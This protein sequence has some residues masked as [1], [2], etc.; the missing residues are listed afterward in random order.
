M[1]HVLDLTV[2]PMDPYLQGEFVGYRWPRAVADPNPNGLFLQPG[3]YQVFFYA[4]PAD[5]RMELSYPSETM[6]YR[7]SGGSPPAPFALLTPP[8]AT[9]VDFSP[10]T[11]PSSG[12]FT[13]EASHAIS[14]VG[15]VRYVFRLWASAART[16]LVYESTPQAP[17][18]LFLPPETYEDGRRYW[19]DVVAVDTAGNA[20]A[21]AC[22]SFTASL[23][24]SANFAF[25][26]GRVY[27]ASTGVG[28]AGSL[29]AVQETGLG[30]SL[31]GGDYGVALFAG[32]CHVKASAVGYAEGPWQGLD[33]KPGSID[34]VD[35]PLVRIAPTAF[36]SS[37]AP[38]PT[39]TRLI[40]VTVVFGAAVTGFTPDDI[41]VTNGMVVA[42]SFS[43]S[44]ASYSLDVWPTTDG[45]VTV[46]IA[47][48]VCQDGGG[49]V[50]AT[51]TPLVRVYDSVPPNAPPVSAT[52]PPTDTTP[53]WTWASAGGG[54]TGIFRVQLDGTAGAWTETSLPAF[55][56]AAPL[57]DGLHT[58]FIQERDAAGNWSASGATVV[59]IDTTAPTV[60]L[61]SPAVD[62]TSADPIAVTATCSEA[63]SGFTLS[64]IV[65][66][67]GTVGSFA[68]GGASYNFLVT[69]LTTSGPVTVAIAAGVC[70]DAAGNSNAAAAPLTRFCD[71]VAPGVTLSSTEADPTNSSPF[72]VSV[73]FSEAVGDVALD[74]V[75]VTNGTADDITGSGASY[76]FLVTP[77]EQG[78]VT[79]SIAGGRCQDSAGNLNTASA[80]LRRDYDPVAPAAP[81]V[82]GTTPTNDATPTWS[83]ASGGGGGAGVF[84]YQLDSTAGDWSETTALSFSPAA[85]LADGVHRLYVQERDA[86]GN[87][88]ASGPFAVTVD[89]QALSVTVEQAAGQADPTN[90]S[91]VH[92]TVVFSEAVNGFESDDVSITGTA[93]GPRTAMVSGSGATYSVTVS[94]M[95]G[96]GTVVAALGA[97]VCQDADGNP[98]LASTSADNTVTRDTAPP[99][100]PEISA[101]T[102]TNDAT[103]TWSWASSGG[104]GAGV[105]RYQLDSTAGDWSETTA[106]SFSPAATLA[107]GVH[108]LYVQERDAAGNWSASDPF[109]V[110]VDVQ[111]LSVTVEQAA[112]Q[113]DPTNGSTVQFTVV[114]SEAV[115]GFESDDVTITGTAPGTR[116]AMVSGSGTTYSVT[117]SGMSGDGTVVAALGA[118]V[119]QDTDSNPNLASTSAD[120]TVTR[121]TTPPAAPEISATTPTHDATPT[122]SWASGGGGGA[123][124]FRYQLDST[125]GD[126]S[127][128]TALSFASAAALADGVHQ[129]FVQERDAAGNWSVSGAAAVTID[130]VPPVVTEVDSV[131]PDGTYVPGTVI[132]VSVTFS[133][134]V[135]VTGLPQLLLETGATETALNCTG[136]SGTATLVFPYTVALGQSSADLDCVGPAALFLNG[137]TIHDVAGNAADLRLPAPG[138]AHSLGANRNLVIRTAYTVRFQPGAN[139][140]LAGGTPGVSVTVDCGAPAPAP[141]EV[142][143]RAGWLF[144]GWSLTLPATIIADAETTATYAAA[145]PVPPHG[146]FLVVVDAAAPPSNRLWD[147]TGTYSTAVQGKPLTLRLL[148]EPTGRLAGTATYAVAEGVAITMPIKGSVKGAGG[149]IT[150]KGTMQ[151]DDST[152]NVSV[153]LTLNLTVDTGNRR[154]VG[155]LTGTIATDAVTTPVHED[156]TLAIPGEM[157]GTWTLRLDPRLLG[158]AVTGTAELTL[159]N[160]VKY[161]FV[162][163]GRTA[164]QTVL[165]SLSGDPGAK[166]L[167]IKVT[168]TPLEGGSARLEGFL[169]KGYGQTLTW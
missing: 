148:H 39:N 26:H 64:D 51:A 53:S 54:G 31:A 4:E 12:V 32:P 68:G 55:T 80:P 124:V 137:G 69:P 151:G 142:T 100:V 128:T 95:S 118:G 28:I 125:A 9:T 160:R 60:T 73:T 88:S 45:P 145:G 129:L 99:A 82:T 37:S 70:Q 167:T 152:R 74:D 168:L 36:L 65:V 144:L 62:P 72:L 153:S 161:A 140:S 16:A 20:T 5:A 30:L 61:S 103:P 11:P 112:G 89:V 81:T 27:D 50:N 8:D 155:R 58:L 169:G 41:T 113:A 117:V 79:V 33:L 38:N 141:P 86:A 34:L 84:R 10:A 25:V 131:T 163:R 63:V 119:C 162:I 76:R 111:A 44:G 59:T 104:G 23:S 77:T 154:L 134:A 158:R 52:T 114:F 138:A 83:W 87:W 159:S 93:P 98:N 166:S 47:A 75:T 3:A 66:L 92:F 2:E 146:S 139:G 90:G 48:G 7:A 157:D 109:A 102:P 108:R 97:G 164:G 78:T 46:S 57:P 17:P 101:T 24:N 133:T 13:W 43:G 143:P 115:N 40:P 22:F 156:L 42:D 29:F 135:T 149:S 14:A 136:G 6:V 96:D 1:Q 21:S 56:A 91:T 122:W 94:G 147:L 132:I 18:F 49:N 15:E 126:W 116:T 35:F 120:N 150:L 19:W 123:G 165:L 107:D 127:E 106:L 121:D 105:F 67:N 130:T 71:R 110:T 85:T